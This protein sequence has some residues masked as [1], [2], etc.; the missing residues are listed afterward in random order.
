MLCAVLC[1]SSGNERVV[2]SSGSQARV[3]VRTSTAGKTTF[4]LDDREVPL[5]DVRTVASLSG[6]FV[7]MEVKELGHI[8]LQFDVESSA[9]NIVDELTKRKQNYERFEQYEQSSVQSY[10]QYYAKCSNQQNMLQDSV[11]TVTYRKAIVENPDDFRGKVAMDIGAGSGILSF[12]ACQAGASTVY[13][14]EASSMGE[15]VRALADANASAFPGSTVEVLN[16]PLESI[17]DEVQGKVDVL[18]SEPIGTF[19]FN[20]RMIET[21]LCARDRFLKP[22]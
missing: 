3:A 22:G 2:P 20:E 1:V 13:A 18:V 7:T 17:K 5:S 4:V 11:R 8:G 16:K 19:L 10:F 9:K 6:V 12:F 15:V 21:Y 14:V